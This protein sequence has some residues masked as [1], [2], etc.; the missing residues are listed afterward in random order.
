MVVASPE[1]AQAVTRSAE[2]L[3]H[4]VFGLD[5]I[6]LHARYWA[7]LGVQVVRVGEPSEVVHH[8][9]L[10]LLLDPRS[11][12]MFRLGDLN[13]ALNW[14]APTVLTLRLR[15]TRERGYRERAITADAHAGDD[16]FVRYHRVYDAADERL[17]RAA[18]TPDR[19]MAELWQQA[20]DPIH[21]WKRLRKFVPRQ[22]RAVRSVDA[23]VF[24]RT[25]DDDVA[26][27]V[28][29]LVETWRRPHATIARAV[30]AD[31]NRVQAHGEAW[32]DPAAD[33]GDARFVGRVWV[34]A[35]RTLPEGGTVVGPAVLWDDPALRPA[36][37]DV[38]E[39]IW[40]GLRSEEHEFEGRPDEV[41][42][43]R[44][45]KARVRLRDRLDAV[46]KRTF[47]IAFALTA[48]VLVLPIV[49][50]ILFAIW[51]EDGRPFLF[52]HTRQSKG[53]RPF[54]CWKFRSMR[55]DAEEM[56]LRL[57]AE[58]KN[59]ADGGQFFMEDDPRITRI[60]QLLRKTNLDELPQ[61]WNVLVGDM[62]V[63]GPR[64]SPDKENQYNPAWRELRLSVRPGI[65]GLWQIRR[66]RAEG[67]DFQEWIRYD[68]EYVET[69]SFFGDIG[70]IWQTVTMI[71]RK[72]SRS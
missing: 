2:P 7:S 53:G 11:L 24:E 13:E 65:T 10:Y 29:R 38:G 9:E 17:G 36:A 43:D 49:P 60:G 59:E 55:N 4:T 64:P 6:Q 34:G 20:N 57:I 54:K 45:K 8:A 16:R 18:L 70:I 42:E 58:G 63:V 3:L 72:L 56:K 32:V 61:F 46:A 33:A 22:E 15:D 52:G 1:F 31:S 51:Y 44:R 68:S 28:E 25:S 27:M 62:S 69:R 50:F 19:E 39:I 30:P 47:D 71:L 35:G 41:Q 67:T 21:G 48:G 5:P 66:T 26:R 12:P 40:P 37:K 23:Q 14:V